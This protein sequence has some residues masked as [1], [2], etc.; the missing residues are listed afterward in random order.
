MEEASTA[1]VLA[2]ATSTAEELG[3]AGHGGGA[4]RRPTASKAAR[5]WRRAFEPWGND[6]PWPG[7]LARAA[8]CH[9]A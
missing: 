5:V 6:S 4:R 7:A 8:E 9:V 3:E 1:E 2:G